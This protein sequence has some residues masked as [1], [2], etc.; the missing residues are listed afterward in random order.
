MGEQA[1]ERGREIHPGNVVMPRA[2]DS[3]KCQPYVFSLDK[4]SP[5]FNPRLVLGKNK[6]TAVPAADAVDLESCVW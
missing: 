1:L 3:Y 6:D 2:A 5:G 4:H